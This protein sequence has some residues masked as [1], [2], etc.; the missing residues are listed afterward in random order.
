MI[1]NGR[2]RQKRRTKP[3]VAIQTR[4]QE[5]SNAPPHGAHCAAGISLLPSATSNGRQAWRDGLKAET[6]PLDPRVI[7]QPPSTFPQPSNK[8]PF[9]ATLPSSRATQELRKA[10]ASSPLQ[11]MMVSDIRS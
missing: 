2:M 7:A 11:V 3:N 6:M 8:Y 9:H 5:N 1:G 4:T 10:I